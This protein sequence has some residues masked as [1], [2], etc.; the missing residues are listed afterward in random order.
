MRI[1]LNVCACACAR[2]WV[3]N[4]L[5]IY[6]HTHAY[7]YIYILISDVELYTI[8]F[9]LART[10]IYWAIFVISFVCI[11]WQ[12]CFRPKKNI[13][14]YFLSSLLWNVISRTSYIWRLQN[15][16]SFCWADSKVILKFLSGSLTVL[17]HFFKTISYT[18][19]E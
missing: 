4:H 10:I 5:Y 6:I 12:N 11:F 14:R 3:V 1:F 19:T 13:L 8:F 17:L 7:I 16:T 18:R 2:E 9:H 15:V